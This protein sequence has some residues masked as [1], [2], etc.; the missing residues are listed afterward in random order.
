MCVFLVEHKELIT[1]P[2]SVDICNNDSTTIYFLYVTI[3]FFL[4]FIS[5][6]KII[7]FFCLL[8]FFK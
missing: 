1:N 7:S 3:L 8:Y 4:K 2:L 6:F 5:T